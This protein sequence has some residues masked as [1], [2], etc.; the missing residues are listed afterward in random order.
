MGQMR[1]LVVDDNEALLEMTKF[2]LTE[3][4]NIVDATSDAGTALS[5]IPVF[6][7]D[8]ILMDIQ[9]PVIDGNELTKRLKANPATRNI[10]VIAYTAHASKGDV[11]AMKAT[12]FDGYI[13]KPVD[14]TTLAAEV[15]FWLEGPESARRSYFVWP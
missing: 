8:V 11:H 12:G 9:M 4:G 2:V 10:P 15:A 13:G 6:L 14:V 1:V 5:M 7:P 3:A